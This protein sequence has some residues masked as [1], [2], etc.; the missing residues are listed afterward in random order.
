MDDPYKHNYLQK[1]NTLTEKN[2]EIASLANK[3]TAERHI[4]ILNLKLL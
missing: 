4:A 1:D 3:S 2:K